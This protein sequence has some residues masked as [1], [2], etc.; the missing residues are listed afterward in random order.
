[1]VSHHH[2]HRSNIISRPTPMSSG[3][4]LGMG[5]DDQ[6]DFL[7]EQPSMSHQPSASS[8]SA[9]A[10]GAASRPRQPTNDLSAAAVLVGLTNVI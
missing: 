3:S 8:V 7:M 2:H 5:H 4:G 6:L 10:P 1:M 9:S